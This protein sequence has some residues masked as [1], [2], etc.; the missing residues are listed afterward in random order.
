MA[1][2][3]S[4]IGNVCIMTDLD[5]GEFIDKIKNEIPRAEDITFHFSPEGMKVSFKVF[6][7]G[8]RPQ[9]WHGI[10]NSTYKKFVYTFVKN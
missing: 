8:E 9:V 7:K 10:Y 4:K 5:T 2:I 1:Y 6:N 3:V